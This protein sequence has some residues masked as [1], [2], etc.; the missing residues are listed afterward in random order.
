MADINNAILN[1]EEVESLLESFYE[2]PHA[3]E[4]ADLVEEEG[5]AKYY[6]FKRPNTISGERRRTLYKLY[7]STAYHISRD[8]S[9]YLRASV[10]VSVDSID[11]LSFEIFKNT[12]PELVLANIVRLKPLHGKGAIL[13]DLG[14]CLAIVERAFGSTGRNENESVRKLTDIELLILDNIV[15]MILEKFKKAWE[16]YIAT[17]W[18]VHDTTMESRYINIVSDTEV[19]LLV[20]FTLNLD[21]NFGEMKFLMPVSSLASTLKLFD[22]INKQTESKERNKED[23]ELINKSVKEL[24]ISV[25]GVL[26]EMD[27]NIGD[28]RNLKEGDVIRLN[29]G[30]TDNMK[31][32]VEGKNKF[33]GKLGLLG[34]KKAIQ[35][36][37]LV[38]T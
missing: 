33:Y 2:G 29:S 24:K 8:L 26:D 35:I 17:D 38:K 10:K 18:K 23:I 22:D 31:V 15:S 13:M 1:S 36:T 5:A 20:S 6:D 37:G 21:F 32:T 7:E 9:N 11:E 19:V 12:M 4:Q 27:M 34:S 3:V 25:R 28:L 16:P 30:I 14:L